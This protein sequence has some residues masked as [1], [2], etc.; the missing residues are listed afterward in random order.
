[1]SV[2]FGPLREIG[3]VR[4]IAMLWIRIRSDPHHFCRFAS[5]FCIFKIG[6]VE[7]VGESF[8]YVDYF[9]FLRDVFIRTQTAAVASR[10][11]TILA[12]HLPIPHPYSFQPNVNYTFA[13]KFEYTVQ[14]IANFYSCD[15]YSRF[16]IIRA[17]IVQQCSSVF[18]PVFRIQH[19]DEHPGSYFRELRNNCLVKNT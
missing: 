1:L 5:I 15:S 18:L 6:G 4:E 19:R 3:L 9:V 10:C 17:V 7:C 13:R 2:L 12:T 8:A 14:N 16:C 11:S